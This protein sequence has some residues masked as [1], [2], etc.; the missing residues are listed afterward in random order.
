MISL[1][2]LL[3]QHLGSARRLRLVLVA[4]LVQ[5]LLSV[6]LH[7]RILRLLLHLHLRLLGVAGLLLESLHLFMRMPHVVHV[8]ELLVDV[9][10][11]PMVQAE[12]L[13]VDQAADSVEL[14]HEDEVLILVVIVDGADVLLE[15]RVFELVVAALLQLQVE[16]AAADLE[17]VLDDIF[18]LTAVLATLRV[19]NEL[20]AMLVEDLSQVAVGVIKAD[21]RDEMHLVEHVDEVHLVVHGDV[22]LNNGA[23]LLVEQLDLRRLVA[24]LLIRALIGLL[25]TV[26]GA[27]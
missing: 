4:L 8:L 1:R 16:D 27:R 18:A 24:L 14:V 2:R 23:V 17:E 9:L 20:L 7:D 12:R 13:P 15:Q 26:D 22:S 10:D 19:D 5:A 3:I 21:V 11:L 25:H 6:L